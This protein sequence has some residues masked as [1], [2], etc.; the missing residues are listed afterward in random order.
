MGQPDTLLQRLQGILGR[1]SIRSSWQTSLWPVWTHQKCSGGIKTPSQGNNFLGDG[2][3]HTEWPNAPLVKPG[4]ELH[5][6]S[7]LSSVS[8]Q[9]T[10]EQAGELGCHMGSPKFLCWW[11]REI[12]LSCWYLSDLS[13]HHSYLYQDVIESQSGFIHFQWIT[14][15]QPPAGY[16]K[17]L[18]S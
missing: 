6:A 2:F 8:K 3:F 14:Q 9:P 10:A 5:T 16:L 15:F 18:C 17:V 4:A 13:I 1:D 11:W 12:A 7:F